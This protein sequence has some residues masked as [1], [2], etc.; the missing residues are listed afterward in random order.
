MAMAYQQSG[1]ILVFVVVKEVGR[2]FLRVLVEC[3]IVRG[4]IVYYVGDNCLLDVVPRQTQPRF[5]VKAS[6]TMLSK[7]FIYLQRIIL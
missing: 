1:E 3:L 2:A 6:D 5:V 4:I 7:K